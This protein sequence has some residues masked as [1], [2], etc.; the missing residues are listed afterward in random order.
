[1]IIVGLIKQIER[2]RANFGGEALADVE[3]FAESAIDVDR[4]IL[5]I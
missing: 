1:M 3:S 4:L 2:F 5:N